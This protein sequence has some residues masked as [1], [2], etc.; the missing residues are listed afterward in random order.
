MKILSLRLKNLNSL[1]G[2]WKID[3]RNAPFKDNGLF[4]ITGPTGAGKSTLLDAICLALY[5]QTPR[6]PSVGGQSNEVMTRHTA[7]CLAEVA[8]EVKGEV[9]RAFWSQRRARDR[10]DGALQPPKVELAQVTGLDGEAVIL[11]THSTDKLRRVAALTG[12]DFPRFTRSMLLAQGGF[13][14]FLNASANDRAELLEELTG[15]DIYG[16]ISQAVFERAREARQTLAQLQAQADG[17]QV[18]SPEQRQTLQAE[19]ERLQGEQTLL[20]EQLRKASALRQWQRDRDLAEQAV[21]QAEQSQRTATQARADAGPDLARLASQAPAQRLQ[22]MHQALRRARQAAVAGEAA[23]QQLQ[24]EQAQLKQRHNRHLRQ[25]RGLAAHSAADAR[26]Q[27]TQLQ[28]EHRAAND[29][30]TA[31]TAH[32]RLGEQLEG[33]RLRLDQRAQHRQRLL[34]HAQQQDTLAREIRQVQ[35]QL[36]QQDPL[37][38]QQVQTHQMAQ[39]SLAQAQAALQTQLARHGAAAVADLRV[40]WQQL[41]HQAQWWRALAECA[42]LRRRLATQSGTLAQRQQTEQVATDA[43]QTALQTLR[44][45]FKQQS[46]SVRDKERLLAQERRIQSLEVHRHALKPGDACPLCGALDHPAIAAYA[47]LDVDATEHDLQ[48]AQAALESLRTQGEQAAAQLAAAQERTTQLA[49]QGQVVANDETQAQ[50]RWQ[51]LLGDAP[52]S[53]TAPGAE[54]WQHEDRLS[55]ALTEG[56]QQVETLTQ[57]LQAAEA[58]EHAVA[59]AREHAAHSAQ[60]V[61]AA[62]HARERLQQSLTETTQRQATAA[63]QHQALQTELDALNAQL[64]QAL[65]DGGHVPPDLDEAIAPWLQQREADWQGWQS[66]QQRL[67]TLSLSLATQAQRCERADAEAA[68]WAA[69]AASTADH[70]DAPDAEDATQASALP[71]TLAECGQAIDQMGQ[72]LHTLAGRIDAAQSQLARHNGEADQA[73]AAW[74]AA[75]Q[76]SPFDSEDAFAQALLPEAEH[77][78]LSELAERLNAEVQRSAALLAD[79]QT[80]HAALL[81]QALTDEPADQLQARIDALQAQRDALIA[82]LAEARTRLA[83][84]DQRRSGQRALLAR[85]E[86]HRADSDVWQR[87]DSLI[88]SARGDKYRKFAQGL[89]LD[90]LLHLAN[91]HL[92][93]LHGRY[94]LR[95]KPSG[96]LELEVVDGWQGDAARDTRTLSGG[97]GFLVSLALALALS[98]LVSRKTSIDSLFLDEGFGTLDGDTLEVALA[99]LDALNARGKMIGVISHVEALKERIPVQIRVDKGGGVGHSRLVF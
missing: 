23:L 50:A 83:D 27:W 35:A 22:P 98:D 34:T 92:L 7:D 18:L 45:R 57:A 39:A 82:Q 1:K 95:R 21:A 5:H 93:R 76:A 79:A 80:R 56:T 53:A 43:A 19:S 88:G 72:G 42:Q 47:A 70:A 48:Q 61:Q 31:H 4:A 94:T 37:V 30:L 8:F 58:A 36:A 33:W 46:G 96:E 20:Q 40:R 16:Q 26:A 11:S 32:A 99:A 54:D 12:L 3:F 89:T 91:R 75:L 29:Y 69:Q 81:A 25:A 68:H 10:I 67:Q 90:H 60:A 59:T 71:T 63:A 85:I 73:A 66:T 9:Y 55:A 65:A 2:E 77:Q 44:E 6:L 52:A 17:V 24:G 41:Q 51:A 87:L 97:E 86:H 78:R 62:E 38:H 74:A 49:A 28:A 14:A 13:A 15:T 64:A 84:D